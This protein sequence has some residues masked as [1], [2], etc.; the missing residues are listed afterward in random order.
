MSKTDALA[1]G[2][3]N[4]ERL[5][6]VEEE[7]GDLVATQGGTLLDFEAKVVGIVSARRGAV[8]LL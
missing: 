2:S 6:G 4:V 7:L 8:D 3:V 1:L 5:L